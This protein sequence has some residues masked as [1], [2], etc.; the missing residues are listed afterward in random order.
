MCESNEE[1]D[2]ADHSVCDLRL[3]KLAGSR[4]VLIRNERSQDQ[5][6][7]RRQKQKSRDTVFHDRGSLHID[8]RFVIAE[9]PPDN[10]RGR[11]CAG[12]RY[13]EHARF[14]VHEEKVHEIQSGCLAEQ[15]GSRISDE[16][17]R[18]LQVG[19][20]GDADDRGHRRD[21]EPL[22]YRQSYRRQHQHGCHVVNKRGNKACKERHRHD[23][24]LNGM[25]MFDKHIAQK[26]RH[27]R[28]NK[29]IHG[30][31]RSGD[32]HD[33]VPVDF[34]ERI[35]PC[36]PEFGKQSQA[37]CNNENKGRCNRDM[38]PYILK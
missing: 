26:P 27:F 10:D 20:D 28:I 13:P 3:I 18:A 14:A 6:K 25:Y 36:I 1:I 24:P 32:H 5:R 9:H 21:P 33:D 7:D 12:F 29:E 23:H 11:K 15:N 19:G 16:R 30:P 31:H 17:G 8:P 34:P 37:A 2:H 38:R 35:H 4:A 22:A